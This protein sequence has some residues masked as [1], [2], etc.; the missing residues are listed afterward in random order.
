MN[1]YPCPGHT[2]STWATGDALFY[3]GSDTYVY[4]LV[5][6][7]RTLASAATN[8]YI[9]YNSLY[10]T[11]LDKY[12]QGDTAVSCP[13]PSQPGASICFG[14]GST[15][16]ELVRAVRLTEPSRAGLPGHGCPILPTPYGAILNR[17]GARLLQLP[18]VPGT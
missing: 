11:T 9:D 14:D 17:D 10:P 8:V 1:V 12:K 4:G 2:Q 16:S 7:V 3:L 15:G 13:P 6:F 18:P 5:A